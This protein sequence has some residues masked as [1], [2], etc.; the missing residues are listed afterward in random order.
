MSD[1]V[2][3][4]L[5]LSGLLHSACISISPNCNLGTLLEA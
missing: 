5:S 1:I 4:R 3:I 2:D